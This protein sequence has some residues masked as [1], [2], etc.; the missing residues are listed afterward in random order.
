[1]LI[2]VDYYNFKK[3]IV[4]KIPVIHL[5]TALII[6]SDYKYKMYY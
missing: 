4:K 3:I 2:N 1:M 6:V 5:L